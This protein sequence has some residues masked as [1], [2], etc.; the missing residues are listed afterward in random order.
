MPNTH[1]NLPPKPTKQRLKLNLLK[2][3]APGSH[4]YVQAWE[5]KKNL[6]NSRQRCAKQGWFNVLWFAPA[7]HPQVEL[8][9]SASHE[10]SI[11]AA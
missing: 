10:A 4:A 2:S 3:L 8:W 9:P 1:L 11:K 6:Q 7:G 5:C